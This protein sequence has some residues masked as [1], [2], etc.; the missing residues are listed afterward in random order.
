VPSRGK[1]KLSRDGEMP[2]KVQ[3][4]NKGG[5]AQNAFLRKRGP[6][7]FP[8]AEKTGRAGPYRER[9][10]RHR[11]PEEP[12]FP[13]TKEDL[14]WGPGRLNKRMKERNQGG[15]KDPTGLEDRGTKEAVARV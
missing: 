2:K 6:D 1:I 11:N 7:I 15:G 8:Q 5:G 13:A 9:T 10:I 12:S 3:K 14:T 4:Q